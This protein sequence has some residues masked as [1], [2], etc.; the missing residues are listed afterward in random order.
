MPEYLQTHGGGGAVARHEGLGLGNWG[1]AQALSQAWTLML[2]TTT[3]PPATAQAQGVLA[4]LG[5]SQWA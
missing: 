1:S 4:A 2:V 3:V 5:L